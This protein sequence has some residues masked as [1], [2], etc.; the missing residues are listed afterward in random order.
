[1]FRSIKA[2]SAC[3]AAFTF[4]L[5]APAFAVPL[6]YD[7]GVSGDI[8]HFTTTFALD[9]GA[10]TV[11][12]TVSNLASGV[13]FD[14][15]N[16][17]LP[18]GGIL[19]SVGLTLTAGAGGSGAFAL[20]FEILDAGFTDTIV[21]GS[22]SG[23]GTFFFPVGQALPS[24]GFVGLNAF[25]FGMVND[26]TITLNVSGGPVAVTEPGILVLLGAGLLGAGLAR[27]RRKAG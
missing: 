20:V 6:A 7:E 15:F 8:V 26:Y 21:S 12:G 19:D 27:R 17:T 13:D 14:K 18:T 3:A 23:G 9:F 2:R 16:A 22:V 10:N 1:M 5:G 25:P 11:S 24:I 4:L